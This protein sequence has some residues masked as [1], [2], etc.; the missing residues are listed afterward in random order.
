MN[1]NLKILTPTGSLFEGE[2]NSV[3][4]PSVKGQTGILPEHAGYVTALEEGVVEV[5]SSGADKDFP[6][7][8]GFCT[9]E[10]NQVIILA[11]GITQN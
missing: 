3:L 6:I 2:V 7:T 4:I 10:E 5:K 11:D 8:G 9:V 1:L